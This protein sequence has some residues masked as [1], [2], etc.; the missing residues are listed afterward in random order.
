MGHP[1]HQP[2]LRELMPPEM[3]TKCIEL[4]PT[5][6]T[7]GGTSLEPCDQEPLRH[8]IID[9]PP[10]VP[11]VTEYLQC[12]CQC[13]D[14]GEFV[15]ASLPDKVKRT[16]FGPGVLALVAI[17]TGELNTSKR[18]ALAM[19]NEVFLVPMSLGGLSNCESQI[20]EV[21]GQPYNETLEHV[22]SQAVAH[23]DE[24]GWRRGNRQRG[25][26]WTLCDTTAAGFMV[27]AKRGQRAAR[28]L[29]GEFF[30]TLV[31]DRWCGYNYFAGI[32]QICWAHLKRD[33]KAISEADGKLGRIG[34]E[35]YS[36]AKK[37]LK[38]RKRARDGTLQWYTFQKRMT[39]LMKRVE[40]LLVEGAT[41]DDKMSG[42]CRNILKH[43]KHLWTFVKD[44][45]VEPTNNTAERAV[46]QGVLWRKISFGTQSERG[47]RYVE[48]IPQRCI[49]RRVEARVSGCSCRKNAF[50][51]DWRSG[52]RQNSP[53]VRSENTPE[54]NRNNCDSSR[55]LA[56]LTRHR[57]SFLQRWGLALSLIHI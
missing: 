3:V 24:T 38:L 40:E 44:Q 43:R 12:V 54:A 21:L 35:L 36:L 57:R 11:E 13:E 28:D 51:S 26:L 53:D 27:H 5:E 16:H 7:C 14:C 47:A 30:G 6:C 25:W 37:L 4:K 32:R 23:A 45:S 55:I 15:Y 18:K 17:L 48:R 39:P 22:R 1:V 31:S 9:I 56:V 52:C 2:H 42:K 20:C 33:F 49:N 41:G 46:R 29:L 50:N 19:M 34:E 10:I 8:Q